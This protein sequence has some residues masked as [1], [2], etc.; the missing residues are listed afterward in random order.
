MKKRHKVIIFLI[1]I[2][3]LATFLY[4]IV[5]WLWVS[6]NLQLCVLTIFLIALSFFG[7]K[8]F[9]SENSHKINE[10]LIVGFVGLVLTLLF[11]I[12]ANAEHE[13]DN[14]NLGVAITTY[15][16]SVAS[17]ILQGKDLPNNIGY[18]NY[19]F[20]EP[21]LQNIGNTFKNFGTA[22]GVIIE[23]AIYTM[24]YSNKLLDSIKNLNENMTV[25]DELKKKF[26][27]E[28]KVQMQEQ[29]NSLFSIMHCVPPK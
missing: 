21:L 15:N 28:Y 16:C 24:N 10:E 19:Y 29:A 13:L 22:S 17:I 20:Y 12:S 26:I 5:H 23:Q 8:R 11:F 7:Y 2:I 6:F 27:N 9:I 25:P 14:Y 1:L 18:G 4:P 3:I